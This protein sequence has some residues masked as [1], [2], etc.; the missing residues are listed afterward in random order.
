MGMHLLLTLPSVNPVIDAG[1]V[2]I[3]N[4]LLYGAALSLTVAM[5]AFGMDWAQKPARDARASEIAATEKQLSGA[6]IRERRPWAGI[7][8]ST[9]WLGFGFLLVSIIIRTWAIHRVPLGNMFEFT[10]VGTAMLLGAWLVW[11]RKTDMR[12]MGIFV[13]LPAALFLFLAALVYYVEPSALMPSLRSY[14]LPIHVGVA[15]L[16]TGLFGIGAILTAL[17]L[18]TNR[19]ARQHKKGAVDA[20]LPAPEVLDRLAY[21]FHI[22]AL[23]L[24]MFTIILG[25]IWAREAW[26]QYWNWDPKETWSLVVFIGYAAYFHARATIGWEG[27]KAA[28]L[29]LIAFLLLLANFGIVNVYFPGQHSYSGM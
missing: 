19:R 24:W 18:W 6:E 17:F 5:I 7:G 20:R 21:Q 16:S 26:G 9:S 12:W 1:Q 2:Q 11:S 3:G 25:A 27:R 13:T 10:L 14:W 28:V 15:A 22:I 29:A 4:Y 8:M 23:P